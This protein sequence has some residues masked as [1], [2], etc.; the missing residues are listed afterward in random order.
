[1]LR[2]FHFTQLARSKAKDHVIEFNTE[3]LTIEGIEKTNPLVLTED[4]HVCE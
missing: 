1:M 3:A 4:H 2:L